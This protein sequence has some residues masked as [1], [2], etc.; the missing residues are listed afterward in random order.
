MHGEENAWR[1]D[2]VKEGERQRDDDLRSICA[3]S[4]FCF[5]FSA[6]APNFRVENQYDSEREKRVL[7]RYF[8][9]Y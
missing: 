9:H 7:E 1:E 5:L 6:R 4:F 3:V 2:N 8:P